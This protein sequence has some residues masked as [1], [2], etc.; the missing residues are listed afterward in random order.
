MNASITWKV[1]YSYIKHL[2]PLFFLVFPDVCFCILFLCNTKMLN[3]AV[4]SVLCLIS[5]YKLSKC[6]HIHLEF[7]TYLLLVFAFHYYWESN[8]FSQSG[9][10]H[11]VAWFTISPWITLVVK[12]RLTYTQIYKMH[13]LAKISSYKYVIQTVVNLK[14]LYLFIIIYI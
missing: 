5:K 10:C 3:Q 1:S 7:I 12:L 13:P 6:R 11:C 2:Y 9:L 4:S 8:M 14:L